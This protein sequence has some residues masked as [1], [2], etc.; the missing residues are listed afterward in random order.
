[1]DI[2]WGKQSYLFSKDGLSKSQFLIFV[3][4]CSPLLLS[5]SWLWLFMTKQKQWRLSWVIFIRSFTASAWFSSNVCSWD[6]LSQNPKPYCEEPM[7]HREATIGPLVNINIWCY[8]S[9]VSQIGEPSWMS[10][11]IKTLMTLAPAT[12]YKHMKD[13]E[14]LPIKSRLHIELWDITINYFKLLNLE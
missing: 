11:L 7:P 14:N 8:P 3:S 5:L 12:I 2:I 6:D 9:N 1:M 13:T 4:L 10:R